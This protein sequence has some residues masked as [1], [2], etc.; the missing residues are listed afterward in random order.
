[1]E[2]N[3][4][5]CKGKGRKG[6]SRSLPLGL[7]VSFFFFGFFHSLIRVLCACTMYTPVRKCV[8]PQFPL[9][10]LISVI[11]IPFLIC[12]S[13][14]PFLIPPLFSLTLSQTHTHA[15]LTLFSYMLLILYGIG[16]VLRMLSTPSLSM[17]LS[18]EKF[19][20][21][22]ARLVINSSHSRTK[23]TLHVRV[24]VAAHTTQTQ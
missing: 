14:P 12:D 22:F 5:W 24:R 3:C 16:H 19:C 23:A 10:I 1:M 17:S 11:N 7:F 20:L 13:P 15:S 9:S 21:S 6:F 2:G 8:S 18:P 4:C